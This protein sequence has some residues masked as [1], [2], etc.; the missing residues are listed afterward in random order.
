MATHSSILAWRIPWTEEP[1]RLQSMGSQKSWTWPS[2]LKKNRQTNK[3]KNTSHKVIDKSI[4]VMDKKGASFART[5]LTCSLSTLLVRRVKLTGKY[6][7]ICL[8]SDLPR[9]MGWIH[10]LTSAFLDPNGRIHP[11]HKPTIFVITHSF[12]KVILE[13]KSWKRKRVL[14]I[15]ALLKSLLAFWPNRIKILFSAQVWNSN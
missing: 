7:P 2:G 11:S 13:F 12:Q 1:G 5:I 10:S 8:Y 3:Q 14:K 9:L 15:T 6:V 4:K